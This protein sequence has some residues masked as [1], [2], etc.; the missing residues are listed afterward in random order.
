M[1]WIPFTQTR[2]LMLEFPFLIV[3]LAVV[4]PDGALTMQQLEGSIVKEFAAAICV[5][6]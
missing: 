2:V 5:L 3:R 6:G 4:V 1:A